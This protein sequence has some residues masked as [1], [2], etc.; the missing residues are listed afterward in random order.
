MSERLHPTPNDQMHWRFCLFFEVL[1]LNDC[2]LTQT[3]R[4]MLAEIADWL[5]GCKTNYWLFD[6]N[7][8]FCIWSSSRWLGYRKFD[9]AKWIDS[10]KTFRW[11]RLMFFRH[12]ELVSRFRSQMIVNENWIAELF[13]LFSWSEEYSSR[14]EF[15]STMFLNS[16]LNVEFET[17][18]SYTEIFHVWCFFIWKNRFRADSVFENCYKQQ[19]NWKSKMFF[20]SSFCRN[21]MKSIIFEK[22]VFTDCFS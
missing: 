18:H 22:I 1:R 16:R 4:L 13:F 21:Q 17:V 10:Y 2:L 9:R 5:T 6:R 7:V 3:K 11:D 19:I 15:D 12:E 20:S 14:N 8:D